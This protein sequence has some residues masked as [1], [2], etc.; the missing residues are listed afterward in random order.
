MGQ[1]EWMLIVTIASM[2]GVAAMGL[3]LSAAVWNGSPPRPV[4]VT[5]WLG[6][7]VLA[8]SVLWV[9]WD[10]EETGTI[11]AAV[12]T[13]EPICFLPDAP[14]HVETVPGGAYLEGSGNSSPAC[15]IWAIIQDPRTGNLWL[16]G[17]A[18][19]SASTWSLAISLATDVAT[20]EQLTYNI[21]VAIVDEETHE[22]WL[23]QALAGDGIVSL[24][25]PVA[26]GWFVRDLPA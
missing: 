21:S 7:M 18:S 17:P 22:V 10:D 6:I 15:H 5:T 23:R 3:N 14:V 11:V 19:T 1:A 9:R 12:A 8:A 2:V 24:E 4:P 25:R 26:A 16:Q 20:S 13:A